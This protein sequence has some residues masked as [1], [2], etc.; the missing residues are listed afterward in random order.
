M[1]FAIF[2][3]LAGSNN[4]IHATQLGQTEFY[5]TG[6]LG[7]WDFQDRLSQIRCPTLILSGRYDEAT[8]AQMAKL[9]EG[10]ADSDQTI[11]EQSSHCGMWEEPDKYRAA[12]GDFIRRVESAD[13]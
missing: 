7:G 2:R 12:I 6:I 8:P 1:P 9:K 11:L 3:A 10:I 5:P 13:A 4:A